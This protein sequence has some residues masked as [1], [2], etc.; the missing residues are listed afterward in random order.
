MYSKYEFLKKGVT[1]DGGLGYLQAQP[2]MFN[3]WS[4]KGD[5]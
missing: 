2:S 5:Y 1:L 4:G 3:L